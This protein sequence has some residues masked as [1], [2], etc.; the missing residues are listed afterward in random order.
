[1]ANISLACPTSSFDTDNKTFFSMD[2]EK[3]TQK[4]ILFEHPRHWGNEGKERF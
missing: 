4:N 3:R 1:M 2:I